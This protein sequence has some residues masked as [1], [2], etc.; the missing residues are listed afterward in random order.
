VLLPQREAR[1]GGSSRPR[2]D[3]AHEGKSKWVE[4]DLPAEGSRVYLDDGHH[5]VTKAVESRLRGTASVRV[6]KSKP[7]QSGEGIKHRR[8]QSGILDSEG[9]DGLRRR[10]KRKHEQKV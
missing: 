3:G 5:E 8:A 1:K 9:K 2:G 10:G 7:I 6:E 4:R